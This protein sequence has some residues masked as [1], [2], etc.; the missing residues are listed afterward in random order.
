MKGLGHTDA[1]TWKSQNFFPRNRE[2]TAFE[3][4]PFSSSQVGHTYNLRFHPEI[5]CTVYETRVIAYTYALCENAFA[6]GLNRLFA[7]FE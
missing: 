1:H 3:N 7:A 6:M 2:G 5:N 4:A